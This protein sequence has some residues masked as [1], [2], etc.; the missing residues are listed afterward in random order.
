MLVHQFRSSAG[1]VINWKSD[2]TIFGIAVNDP[3]TPTTSVLGKFGRVLAGFCSLQTYRE[4]EA[5]QIELPQL[6]QPLPGQRK[7]PFGF[8]KLF[9]ATQPVMLRIAAAPGRR[10]VL[11][12]VGSR[13][14]VQWLSKSA[15]QGR[16]TGQVKNLRG[17]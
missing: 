17:D 5:Q 6:N 4:L 7:Y 1:N 12:S 14:T 15:K 13:S 8:A 9:M 2:Q 3:P 16:R 10:L 11:G